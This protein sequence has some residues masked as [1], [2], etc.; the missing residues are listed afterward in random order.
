MKSPVR[1]ISAIDNNYVLPFLTM[2]YSAKKNSNNSFQIVLGYDSKELS[3]TNRKMIANIL[4]FLEI[5]HSFLEVELSKDMFSQDHISSTMWARLIMADQLEGVVIW[6]DSDLICLKGWDDLLSIPSHQELFSAVRDSGI[7]HKKISGSKNRAIEIMKRDY[8]NSGVMEI[9]CN[10]WNRLHLNL[11]WPALIKEF[12]LYGFEWGDQCVLNYLSEGRVNY[13]NENFNVLSYRRKNWFFKKVKILHFASGIKP[14]YYA[15]NDYRI[16]ISP[17]PS[18]DIYRY[19]KYQSEFINSVTS[20]DELIGERLATLQIE[21]RK[22]DAN[23][24]SSRRAL[25]QFCR[26]VFMFGR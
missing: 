6:L 23:Y 18:F 17:L 5:E 24:F 21:S 9:N 22:F 20:F 1:V 15:K 3:Q 26:N 8:F 2:C 11:E 13:L 25:L 7:S 12:D 14:W 4:T 16:L 19:L 10:R